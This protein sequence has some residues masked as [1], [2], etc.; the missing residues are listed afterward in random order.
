[1]KRFASFF[2]YYSRKR[3]CV[4]LREVGWEAVLT[5]RTA[6][7]SEGKGNI[8][9]ETKAGSMIPWFGDPGLSISETH[10]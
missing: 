7:G 1:M 9:K 4:G 6:A 3:R 2:G 8:L 10:T 5:L